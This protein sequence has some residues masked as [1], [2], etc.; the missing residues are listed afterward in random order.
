MHVELIVATLAKS[1]GCS[2]L[3]LHKSSF[4]FLQFFHAQFVHRLGDG[5]YD[6]N[7]GIESDLFI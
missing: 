7:A 1:V 6:W 3:F 5:G 4:G 2:N